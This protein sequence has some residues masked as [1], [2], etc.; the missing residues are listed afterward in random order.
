[1]T[2]RLLGLGTGPLALTL[3]RHGESEGNLADAQARERGA[4]RLE[5]DQRDADVELSGT[6]REQADAVG[7]H[8]ASL[9]EGDRPT[10]AIT[11]PY[12]R[13]HETARRAVGDTHLQLIVDERLR[14]RDLG[15]LDGLTGTGIR[16]LYPEEAERRSKVGKFYYQPP[17]G[18]SWAD[19]VL[20]V[21]S[22]LSD[23]RQGFEHE[24]LWLFTH[25]AVIM[26]FRFVLEGLGEADLLDLDRSRPLPNCSLTTYER[27]SDGLELRQFADTTVLD[28][29]SGQVT[30]EPSH[31]SPEVAGHG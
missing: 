26:S 12:A 19:V 5:L 3:V 29:V 22:L 24:R 27:S 11:S 28:A 20:R 21:R 30:D 23:L 2:G 7:R 9:G 10:L 6:G 25:Q 15:Q 13:A 16:Q 17:S 4:E 8:L 18:E 31:A 1:M 14:E